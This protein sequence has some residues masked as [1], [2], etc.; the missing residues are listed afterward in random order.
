MKIRKT[1]TDKCM[2]KQIKRQ[3]G[4]GATY[5]S[6]VIDYHLQFRSSCMCNPQNLYPWMRASAVR[7]KTT[8]T[9]QTYKTRVYTISETT[10][11]LSLVVHKANNFCNNADV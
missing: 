1:K 7:L 6:Q 11:H 8:T 9:N 10:Q 2:Y 3:A 4:S 5:Q